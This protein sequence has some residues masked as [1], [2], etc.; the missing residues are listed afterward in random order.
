MLLFSVFLLDTV[1]NF[2]FGPPAPP[3]TNEKIIIAT[4]V[5]FF[6]ILL[7]IPKK[8]KQQKQRDK[9]KYQAWLHFLENYKQNHP[10]NTK[11]ESIV[12]FCEAE[13]FF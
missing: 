3:S 5:I 6:L 12:Q 7:F 11:E 13:Y 4:F 8:S 10:T 2:S 9:E 1:Q